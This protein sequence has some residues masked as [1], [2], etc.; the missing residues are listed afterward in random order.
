M[1]K[2]LILATMLATALFA[3]SIGQ[4]EHYSKTND[5]SV[6]KSVDRSHTNETSK[7]ISH[8]KG[9][10]VNQGSE[11]SKSKEKEQTLSSE[12]SQS[13][14]KSRNIKRVIDMQA[15]M[16][17]PEIDYLVEKFIDKYTKDPR[18]FM[19]WL[20]IRKVDLPNS[21][22][23]FAEQE[24]MMANR[25][26]MYY[27]DQT[28]TQQM[29]NQW[30]MG[31]RLA[32]GGA[33]GLL[34]ARARIL[35]MSNLL[36]DKFF[37]KY[38]KLFNEFFSI[39][40][41]PKVSVSARTYELPQ[42]YLAVSFYR[43]KFIVDVSGGWSGNFVFTMKNFFDNDLKFFNKRYIL[44]TQ[45]QEGRFILMKNSQPIVEISPVRELHFYGDLIFM[46]AFGGEM[47][48]KNI[49]VIDR[50]LNA[51]GINLSKENQ[52]KKFDDYFKK[53]MKLYLEAFS[54][55]DMS[56]NNSYSL[57][58]IQYRVRE[59]LYRKIT[60]KND[61]LKKYISDPSDF[62]RPK[63]KDIIN[64]PRVHTSYN[65]IIFSKSEG[66]IL[67]Q[68]ISFNIESSESVQENFNRAMREAKSK[69][70]ANNV[71]R[72]INQFQRENKQDMARLAMQLASKIA[73]NKNYLMKQDLIDKASTSTG[74]LGSMLNIVR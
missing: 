16:M 45:P 43:S 49:I 68:R 34:S 28:M 19:D 2:I 70:W 1:Y 7:T 64:F 47:S 50:S 13:N 55:I 25:N 41:L 23:N 4:D 73:A 37:Y 65:D 69:K 63:G 74:I 8:E 24:A 33:N 10:E 15:T 60:G 17:M 3:N 72:A 42:T 56:K 12:T 22:K 39:Y 9:Q 40:G 51:D 59:Y 66:Y 57:E 29:G 53:L 14:S 62:W 38:N 48:N 52:H 21:F 6:Q 27:Q 11:T 5:Q 36:M 58:E 30:A 61:F 67:N 44:Q 46:R 20:P 54:S 31:A 32:Y 26:Y 35:A 71:K 18:T